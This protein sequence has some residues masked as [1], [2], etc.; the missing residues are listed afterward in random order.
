[1]HVGRRQVTVRCE[2]FDHRDGHRELCAV[3]QGTVVRTST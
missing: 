3:A 1:V 2:V